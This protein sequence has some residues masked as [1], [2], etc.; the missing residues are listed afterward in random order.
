MDDI[1]R[2]SSAGAPNWASV[3]RNLAPHMTGHA[4]RTHHHRMSR[5]RWRSAI[6]CRARLAL[7]PKTLRREWATSHVDPWSTRYRS[8]SSSLRHSRPIHRPH[9]H[10]HRPIWLNHLVPYLGEN[11]LAI[12]T[13]KVIMPSLYMGTNNIDMAESLLDELFHALESKLACGL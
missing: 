12:R 13:D 6:A 11:N 10:R 1:W 8:H 3:E 9:M 5:R 4:A 7:R 2:H